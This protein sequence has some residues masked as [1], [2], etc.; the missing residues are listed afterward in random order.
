MTGKIFTKNKSGHF[1]FIYSALKPLALTILLIIFLF[2]SNNVRVD[3]YDTILFLAKRLIPTLFPFAVITQF[4][5]RENPKIPF[6]RY[7]CKLLGIPENLLTPLILGIICGFP[8]GAIL[9][10]ELYKQGVV[11]KR[12]AERIIILS[13]QPSIAFLLFISKETGDIF[14]GK[15]F[16]PVSLLVVLCFLI[17]SKRKPSKTDYLCVISRQSVPLTKCITISGEAMINLSFFV[18]TF[19]AVGSAIK[20]TLKNPYFIAFILPFFEITTSLNYLSTSTIS[21]ALKLFLI[22][23]SVG[24]S[25]LSV[26]MQIKNILSDTDLRIKKYIPIKLLQGLLLGLFIY[27]F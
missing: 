8:I 6:S 20:S 23:F 10:R 25:D 15:N 24:F 3:L 9:V 21:E 7:I 2:N 5:L 12:Q 13:S 4:I 17:F 16:V 18:I 26:F 11:E 14:Y 19:S 1:E 22:P 27:L